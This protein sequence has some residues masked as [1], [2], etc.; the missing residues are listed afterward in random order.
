VFEKKNCLPQ[1]RK[2]TRALKHIQTP[3]TP[4]NNPALGFA[5]LNGPKAL[6]LMKRA[7]LL[8]FWPSI[9]TPF[10]CWPYFNRRVSKKALAE[11]TQ[12][13]ASK[14]KCNEVENWYR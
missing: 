6:G 11:I 9:I 10:V 5:I 7:V 12:R 4:A 13:L 1:R 2:V 14:L 8:I 3:I